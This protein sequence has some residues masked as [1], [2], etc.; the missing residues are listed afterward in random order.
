M[1]TKTFG[2]ELH[3][4]GIVKKGH[5]RLQGNGKHTS[6]VVDKDAL[7]SNTRL[8]SLLAEETALQIHTDVFR[9]SMGCPR[10]LIVGKCHTEVFGALVARQ[11]SIGWPKGSMKNVRFITMRLSS[12]GVYVPSAGL[13][14]FTSFVPQHVLY[15][16]D[17]IW[18]I[19]KTSAD[20]ATLADLGIRVNAVATAFLRPRVSEPSVFGD[21]VS[22]VV[23]SLYNHTELPTCDPGQDTCPLCKINMPLD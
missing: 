18:S 9:Y 7:M 2:R 13:N 8:V 16:A 6:I 19:D 23:V 22:H 5:F 4:A 17:E 11:L 3:E 12:E 20:I 15:L 10:V 1:D 21:R 14:V